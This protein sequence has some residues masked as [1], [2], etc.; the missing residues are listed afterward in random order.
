MDTNVSEEHAAAM[1]RVEVCMT[2]IQVGYIRRLHARWTLGYKGKGKGERVWCGSGGRV[3][4]KT[5]TAITRA[6]EANTSIHLQ[7][8]KVSQPKIFYNSS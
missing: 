8:Y 5:A 3:K 6:K 1:F 4:R 2:R 7:G